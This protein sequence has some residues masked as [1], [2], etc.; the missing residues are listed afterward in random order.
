MTTDLACAIAEMP[1]HDTHEHLASEDRYVA[2]PPDVLR[3]LFDN[4]I[5]G[6][7]AVAGASPEAIARLLDADD[8]DLRARFEGI[9]PAWES[10]RHTGYGDAVRAI[11]R[12]V[13][14]IEMLTASALE[15]AQPMSVALRAPGKRLEI[16][17]RAG[18]DHVQVDDCVWKCAPDQ[19]GPDFFLYDLSWL[20]FS[21]GQVDAARIHA[22]VGVEVTDLETLRGAMEALFVRY[23]P[24]AVAVKTQHAYNRTLRW[25]EPDEATV[26]RALDKTLVGIA[27]DE[28]EFL[29]LGDWCLARGVE[30]AGQFGLP[31]K[32]HTGYYAG[33]SRML[34]DRIP[35]G[36]LSALLARYPQTR[37]VLM[38]IAYPYSDE[39]LALAKHYPNVWVDLC[40]AWSINPLAASDFVRQFVHAAPSNK[41]LGFGGDSVWPWAS[42]AYADQARAWLTRALEVEVTD[43]LLTEQDAIA[44]AHRFLHENQRICF[45]IDG[46]RSRIRQ[47]LSSHGDDHS[48]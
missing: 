48:A 11:A 45:D 20:S 15:A 21:S 39:V 6:D 9:A 42:V 47:A 22:E 34:M 1:L 31:V 43:R 32:I 23:A 28:G 19:S 8:P 5:L 26:A 41:L 17:Q 36:H 18:L 13:F 46:L 33:H 10:C 30:L 44:L 16:L 40:W 27:P 38:H 7:L 35:A 4:Y 24:F 37:F 3:D 2:S 12:D 25:S 14:G 29:A